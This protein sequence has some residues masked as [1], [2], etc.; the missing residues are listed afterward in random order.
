MMRN[1][2]QVSA[3]TEEAVRERQCTNCAGLTPESHPDM[4][5]V[6]FAIAFGEADHEIEHIHPSLV[7]DSTL[8]ARAGR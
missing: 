1:G 3:Q 2:Y 6:C 7:I 5:C 8:A 4:C